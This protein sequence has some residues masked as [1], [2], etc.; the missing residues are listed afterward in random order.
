MSDTNAPDTNG[1][2]KKPGA[3]RVSWSKTAA[4]RRRGGDV[5][6][7]LSPRTVNS[8][9]GFMGLLT[10][11]PGEFVTEHYHPYSEEFFYVTSG[12]L[13][14]RVGEEYVELGP[15]DAAMVPM[16]V[17]HRAENRGTEPVRAVF[18]LGPLAPRPELGHVDTEQLPNPS[19]P[20]S[21]VG[22]RQ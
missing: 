16:G 8:T 22:D 4:N 12:R 11:A 1:A 10:L 14:L 21:L 5:R 19:A 9:S 3:T 2:G 6:V 7:M 18:H 15:D 20:G 13:H 17:R